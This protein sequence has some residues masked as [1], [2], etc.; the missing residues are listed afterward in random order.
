MLLKPL[1]LTQGAPAVN[2]HTNGSVQLQHTLCSLDVPS[3][4]ALRW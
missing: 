3:Y 4:P 2:E 1:L